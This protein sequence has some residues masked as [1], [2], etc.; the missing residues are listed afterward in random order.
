M[1]LAELEN[2][3]LQV[4]VFCEFFADHIFLKIG[5]VAINIFIYKMIIEL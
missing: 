2:L 3:L 4:L 5:S 1:Y